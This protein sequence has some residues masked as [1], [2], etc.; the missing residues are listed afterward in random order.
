MYKR[1]LKTAK[2]D[3]FLNEHDFMQDVFS[4]PIKDLD[5]T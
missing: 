3:N 2:I 1:F 5:I 4:S